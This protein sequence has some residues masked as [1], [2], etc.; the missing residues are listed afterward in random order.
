M[1]AATDAR[2]VAL[3]AI[4]KAGFPESEWAT[5]LRVASAESG[6]NPRAVNTANKNGTSDYGLFQINSI[7]KP[8]ALER[9]DPYAN[10]KRAYQIWK[11]AGN[12]WAPWSAYNNGS[13]LRQSIKIDDLPKIVS[14]AVGVGVGVGGVAGGAAVDAI[15]D[16][17]KAAVQSVLDKVAEFLEVAY[18]ILIGLIL[19]IVGIVIL[20][21]DRVG[22]AVVG[23]ATKGLLGKKGA[24]GKIV[25]AVTK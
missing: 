7:H 25:K 3:D 22:D 1:A 16:P 6:L 23:I 5:A 4:R 2:A 21:K 12:K 10:A 24:A 14:P 13:Y 18:M 17:V 15:A 9:V 8:T 19:I 11:D 20:N